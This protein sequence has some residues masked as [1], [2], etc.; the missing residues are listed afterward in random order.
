MLIYGLDDLEKMF[1]AEKKKIY[2]GTG[3]SSI[4]E[5]EISI[6]MRKR[7]I[8]MCNVMNIRVYDF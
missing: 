2:L 6:V 3:W 4:H 1:V 7:P 8:I 5:R